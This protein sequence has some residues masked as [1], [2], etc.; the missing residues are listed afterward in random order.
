VEALVANVSASTTK[1]QAAQK[2]LDAA[3]RYEMEPEEFLQQAVGG[4][5]V[6]NDLIEKKVIDAQGNL[7]DKKVVNSKKSD[8][9]SLFNLDDTG[10]DKIPAGDEKI[11]ALVAKALEPFATEIKKSVGDVKNIQTSMIRDSYEKDILSKHPNLDHEDVSKVFGL[12]MQDR[13]KDI[14]TIAEAA[15]KVKVEKSVDVE[16]AFAKAHGLNYDELVKN[17]AAE[18]DENNLNEQD[19]KG[20]AAALVKGKQITFRTRGIKDKEN[21]IS[22]LEA[23]QNYSKQID[24][25]G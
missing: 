9:N 16:K 2:V 20:G 6:I 7:V 12:A 5:T 11:A 19:S 21:V 25:G 3:A 17:K 14:W 15:S 13:S 24:A 4:F 1:T 22:P 10:K 18:Q 8:L 23:T